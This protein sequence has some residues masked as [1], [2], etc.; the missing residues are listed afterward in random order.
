[1]PCNCENEKN[2]SFKEALKSVTKAANSGVKTILHTNYEPLVSKKISKE[3]MEI[4]KQCEYHTLLLKKSRCSICGCFL[5]AKTSL[6]EQ[7]CP[8]PDGSKWREL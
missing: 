6:R 5:T 8:H 3:R 7:S 4:C 1:M 2:F